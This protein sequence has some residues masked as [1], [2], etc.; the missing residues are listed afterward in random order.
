MKVVVTILFAIFPFLFA[1]GEWVLDLFGER[2]NVQVLFVMC[3]FPLMM[4][5]IQFWLV[6]TLL[7]HDPVK[8]KYSH[9]ANS[10][11]DQIGGSDVDGRQDL[12]DG[13]GSAWGLRSEDGP[14]SRA[15]RSYDTSEERD[16]LVGSRGSQDEDDEDIDE[17]AEGISHAQSQATASQARNRNPPSRTSSPASGH[18][19]PPKGT[20]ET[21]SIAGGSGRNSP[22][23]STASSK[24]R[25]PA[26]T[27]GQ[28][29]GSEAGVSSSNNGRISPSPA[30]GGS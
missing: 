30:T 24:L 4:N 21:G 20:S 19:Y 14:R 17:E 11:E 8:S 10:S 25:A 12:G 23:G 2:R 27:R 9:K 29:S 6:D 7:R 16:G 3:L 28:G 18:S 15:G 5:T 13:D 22:H 1:F 26:M